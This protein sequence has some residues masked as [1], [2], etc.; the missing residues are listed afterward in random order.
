MENNQYF[1]CPHCGVNLKFQPDSDAGQSYC[2]TCEGLINTNEIAVKDQ[3]NGEGN[4][5][6]K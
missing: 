5:E 2:P 1:E 6:F 3:D 4:F